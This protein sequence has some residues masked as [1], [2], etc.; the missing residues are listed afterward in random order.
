M[1]HYLD[2]LFD[3]SVDFPLVN[4]MASFYQGVHSYLVESKAQLG[5][6]LPEMRLRS[7]SPLGSFIRLHGE[8]KALI[9]FCKSSF[10]LRIRSPFR[11]NEILSVPSISQHRTFWRH[12]PKSMIQMRKRAMKRHALTEEQAV[13]RYPLETQA[14][15]LLPYLELR[16]LSTRQS[17]KLFFVQGATQSK[18]VSGE[19]NTYGLSSTAT[20]PWF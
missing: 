14:H 4:Q 15:S 9:A 12:Q 2:V 13:E 8:K 16:S 19:F 6:T 20:L 11:M 18:P 7:R 17:F 1:D 3:A 10:L 5:V